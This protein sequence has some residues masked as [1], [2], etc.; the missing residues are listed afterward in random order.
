MTLP[1]KF[2]GTPSAGTSPNLRTHVD[3]SVGFATYIGGLVDL[4]KPLFGSTETFDD[5]EVWYQPTPD[6][7]PIWIFTTSLG[8]AGTNTAEAVVASESV[9]TFR[10]SNGGLFRLY[11]M[12]TC[13]PVNASLS[14]SQMSSAET[15]LANA[16]TG[17]A[18]SIYG[19]DDG[20]PVV[21]LSLK[22]KFNDVL[23]RKL[24]TG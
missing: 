12:E 20:K 1:T 2:Q 17:T 23:R 21:V 10:T 15:A 16:L 24:L 18:S 19:R 4:I 22:T 5:A 11:L 6:S 9:M 8:V 14:P 3:G 13:R 7:D